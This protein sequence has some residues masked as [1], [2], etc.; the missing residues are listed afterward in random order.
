MGWAL[1]M[2]IGWKKAMKILYS[3]RSAVC[4]GF[5][6]M[7]DNQFPCVWRLERRVGLWSHGGP[8]SDTGLICAIGSTS[9]T[10]Q[11]LLLQR[12]APNFKIALY[13]QLSVRYTRLHCHW[14]VLCIVRWEARTD[15]DYLSVDVS[16][17][18]RLSVIEGLGNDAMR[19]SEA[20]QLLGLTA[21]KR[22]GE[23][24]AY[25]IAYEIG[26]RIRNARS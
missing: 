24:Y 6:S 7:Q 23:W 26:E 21:S 8:V 4:G 14:V 11:G 2:G 15:I 9:S 22:Y 12:S 17:A 20:K 19:T 1:E 10:A 18:G 16:N 25:E 13:C 5:S 3:N